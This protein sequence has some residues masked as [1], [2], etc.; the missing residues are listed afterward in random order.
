MTHIHYPSVQSANIDI[1][2]RNLIDH[3][4]AYHNH[5]DS[6]SEMAKWDRDELERAHIDAHR[7]VT[8]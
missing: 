3:L 5:I 8:K 6:A 2:K 7:E 4:R 1:R